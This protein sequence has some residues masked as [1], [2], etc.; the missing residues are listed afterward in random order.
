MGKSGVSQAE[1]IHRLLLDGLPHRT[2]EIARVC[3]G[4]TEGVW[5]PRIGARVFD[6]KRKHGFEVESWPDK[7]NPKLWWYRKASP[8]GVLPLGVVERP[9]ERTMHEWR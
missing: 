9:Q 2:D 8:Q 3:Y 5:F 6:A 7:E 1:K 4:I